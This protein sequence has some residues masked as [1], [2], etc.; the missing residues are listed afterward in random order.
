MISVC[1]QV[2][3]PVRYIGVREDGE[4]QDFNPLEFIDSLLQKQ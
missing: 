1:D 2:K 4:P 3:I